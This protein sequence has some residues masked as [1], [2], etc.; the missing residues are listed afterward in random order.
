MLMLTSAIV[1]RG[2]KDIIASSDVPKNNF[3]ILQPPV[4]SIIWPFSHGNF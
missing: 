3:F 1:D 4:N 2:I